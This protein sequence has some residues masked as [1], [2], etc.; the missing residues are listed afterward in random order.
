MGYKGSVE[1]KASEIKRQTIT[2]VTT[3]GHTLNWTPV[4]EQSLI[5]TI[6]GVKQHDSA[7]TISGTTL[8][9]DAALVATDEL[10]VI[11]LMDVGRPFTPAEG[12]VNTS[13]LTDDAVTADKLATGL[14]NAT[15]T[16]DV[17]GSTA[18][19]IA[20]D[21]VD[22]PMLSATGTADATTYLRGDN[23]WT[24]LSEYDD[25]GLQNDI[26]LLGF[27]VASNGSLAKYNLVDQI[28]DDFQDTSGVDA[29]ASTNEARESS[30]KYYYGG[31]SVTPTTSGGTLSTYTDGGI[32]YTIRTFLTGDNFVTDT[33]LTASVLVVA[34]GGGGGGAGQNQGGGGGAGGFRAIA[35]SAI[36]A[37]THAVVVG[38]GG[39]AGGGGGSVGGDGNTSSFNSISA[40]AG[41]GGGGGAAA[42]RTGGS[43]GGAGGGGAQNAGGT[44]NAGS[45]SPVEGYDGAGA[46]GTSTGS[47][48]GGGGGA[49]AVGSGTT[50]GAG[51]A[52]AYR[53][54]SNITYAGGGGGASGGSG[55]AGGGGNAG[56]AGTVNTGGGGGAGAASGGAGAAG[57]SGIVV[58]KFPATASSEGSNM[59]LVSTTTAAQAAPT[60]GDIVFT[61][62]NGAGTTTVGGGSP[63]VTAEISADGGSTWTP[64]TLGAEGSTGS[65]SIVTAHDVTISSTIT[66]PYN[67]AYR[68]KTLNQSASKTTRIH[69]VSLGWS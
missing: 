1:L 67:M 37:A 46:A 35:A 56:S 63:D 31:S 22:I 53:T 44:G 14:A 30:D 2:G 45:Y 11:G 68:I 38:N 27:R 64:M 9:L 32:D 61:Y 28:V 36:S 60:K 16:G 23:A 33:A 42:G 55:G 43:G 34:G 57:G 6:N 40:T 29:S 4:S 41:G 39:S 69:A 5:V 20:V 59:T 47:A 58:V 24:A 66:A 65:H 12:S 10:E 25:S 50:G 48:A 8:T 51:T 17:T 26:A 3:A 52:N 18:L 7:Y 15:H 49:G 21:A 54:G 62:T 13:Q 19:T